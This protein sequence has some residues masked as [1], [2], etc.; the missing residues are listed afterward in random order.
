MTIGALHFT[1]RIWR[2]AT[3]LVCA[4]A[5][6]GAMAEPALQ[7]VE[8][9]FWWTGFKDSRLQLMLH[10]PDIG[11]MEPGVEHPGVRIERVRRVSSPNYLFVYLDL[12]DAA[13]GQFNLVLSGG[14]RRIVHPYL[15]HAK[16]PDP[17]HARG[18]NRADAIYLITPDRFANGD[19]GN[20]NLP[21][22]GDPVD[23]SA[24]QGRHGGDLA[25][26]IRHLDYIADLGFSAIWLNP[27]LENAMPE[28]SYHG[29][30][31]TD[32]YRVDPRLGSNEQYLALARQARRLGLGLI[33]DII[34][35]HC[36][37]RHWWL[38][39]LPDPDWLNHPEASRMTSHQRTVHQDPHAA[40]ADRREMVDGW[41]VPAM[42]DLNQR[43]PLLGDYLIQNAL[44]W[45][46][47]LG[48]AGIRM[49]T[50]PYPDK[51]YMARWTA[52]LMS[53]YPQFNIVG[54]EW[55]LNPAIVSYWQRGKRNADGYST[56]LPSLMDFPLQDAIRRALTE[57][58]DWNSGLIVL[59]RALANDFQ[60]SAPDDLV[61]FLDN[62]DMSRIHTQLGEDEALQRMALGLLA[63]LRGIPQIY[64]GTEILMANRESDDHGLIRSDW[65][66]GWPG[67]AVNAFTGDGM[68]RGQREAR[69]HLRRLLH[70]RRDQ[71]VVHNGHLTHFVPRNGVYT[72]FRHDDA[73]TLMVVLNKNAETASLDSS[74]F[75]EVLGSARRAVDAMTGKR[76]RLDR[77]MRI[78]PRTL[79]LL[80][81]ERP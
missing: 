20:D 36:G 14:G 1:G 73:A 55:S 43:H 3:L 58:E 34:V 16:N 70:W 56:R 54:E 42:P 2:P 51:D 7:R 9:P 47:Y 10:G 13:P 62:H 27:V 5:A 78:P 65:P 39:D 60:Y 53:E 15:L 23:R 28:G 11:R 76:H 71:P 31:T 69:E 22:L 59:Y 30:A 50:W 64:Y 68:A 21:G 38:D 81:V 35:N 66:G 41:F 18:F 72:F 67:D 8:P 49:D 25:G 26:I 52:R 48:L 37:S 40:E 57:P 80:E 45:I 33:M 19:T 79:M 75:A 29:Y 4:L 32:F 12:A 61:I 77:A 74:R 44:W 6:G 46:E 63:S 24:L 17:E